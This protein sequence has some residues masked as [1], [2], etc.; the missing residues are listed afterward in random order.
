M[1]PQQHQHSWVTLTQAAQ[2][3][4]DVGQRDVGHAFQL[5]LDVVG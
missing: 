5:T 3:P 4:D 1:T 2:L